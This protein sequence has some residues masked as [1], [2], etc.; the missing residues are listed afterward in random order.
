MIDWIHGLQLNSTL[1]L[2]LY[3]LPLA[4]CGYGYL[5]RTHRNY[6]KDKAKREEPGGYYAPTD[7]LGTLIG[8]GLVSVV[9]VAN[10]CAATFDLGPEVFGRAFK[11]IGEV[12]DQPLVPDSESA[13][14]KRGE[15]G[16]P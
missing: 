12:F 16:E 10:L 14:A 6:Q 5:L 7:T 3:W 13:K 15:E 11:L 2:L 4:F 9:P 1:G 8:R